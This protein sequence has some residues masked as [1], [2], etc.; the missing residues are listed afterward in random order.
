MD[1]GEMQVAQAGCE[2]FREKKS[3]QCARRVT[4][5]AC[6]RLRPERL[7]IVVFTFTDETERRLAGGAGGTMDE[8]IMRRD[9]CHAHSR[10][11]LPEAG[12]DRVDEQV[13]NERV[14]AS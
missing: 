12:V 11:L 4:L 14:L 2:S 8:W 10:N 3:R 9:P 7:E 13:C 6:V 1:R 5:D